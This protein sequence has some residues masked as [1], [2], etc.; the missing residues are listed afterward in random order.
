[1]SYAILFSGSSVRKV[2]RMFSIFNIAHICA[3]T[4]SWYQTTY[5]FLAVSSFWVE[6][7]NIMIDNI[8]SSTSGLVLGGDGRTDSPG[9]SA[10]YGSYCMADLKT[11]KVL[12]IRL[13]QSNEVK[14]S[15]HMELEGLKQCI[16]FILKQL[17]FP[18]LL[19]I[20][21]CKLQNECI[22]NIQKLIIGTMFG[23]SGKA[24]AKSLT[25]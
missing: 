16:I 24:L 15:N 18:G 1:M 19:Q 23:M 7:Q 9:H 22:K 11:N 20:G 8:R 4:F 12:E 6:Q 25:R 3:R 17:K 13:V 2:L 5:L 10:K 14:S 21:M